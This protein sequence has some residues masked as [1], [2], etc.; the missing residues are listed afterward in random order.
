[1]QR[2][3]SPHLQIYKPQITSVMSILH[4]ATGIFIALGI[5]LI[6][7]VFIALPYGE[8]AYAGIASILRSLIGQIILGLFAAAFFYHLCNGI[9]H[10]CW[11]MVRGLDMAALRKSAV[12]VWIAVAV[13]LIALVF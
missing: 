13:L 4:R 10:L 7:L 6:S 8:S 3:L 12:V 5:A 2:P 11:D 1:M 9:R